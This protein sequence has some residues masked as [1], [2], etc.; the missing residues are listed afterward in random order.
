MDETKTQLEPFIPSDQRNYSLYFIN[1]RENQE[2]IWNR[3]DDNTARDTVELHITFNASL[4]ENW[5]CIVTAL[6]NDVITI[7]PSGAV[8]VHN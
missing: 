6:S 1:T 3:A 2:T 7:Q 5:V 4:T 8:S